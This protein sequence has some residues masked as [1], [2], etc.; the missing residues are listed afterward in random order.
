[1]PPANSRC[2]GLPGTAASAGA[3]RLSHGAL[4]V[5]HAQV[6]PPSAEIQTSFISDRASSQP[7]ATYISGSR[8]LQAAAQQAN[9]CRP[10]HLLSMRRPWASTSGSLCGDTR[11]HLPQEADPSRGSESRQ[12]SFMA[13]RD[14]LPPRSRRLALERKPDTGSTKAAY[15]MRG[16]K[17][18]AGARRRPASPA[19]SSSPRQRSPQGQGAGHLL[20]LKTGAAPPPCASQWPYLSTLM[21][22]SLKPTRV[23][24]Q[25]VAGPSPE[26]RS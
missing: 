9:S 3:A 8:R 15:A 6:F 21:T 4:L 19:Q 5:L 12:T 18:Q 22:R 1:M 16:K 26:S 23:L 17:S 11:V 2:C 10:R 13:A 25:P 24:T 20:S 14:W 7:A